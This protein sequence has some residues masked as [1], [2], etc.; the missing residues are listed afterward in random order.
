M[1]IEGHAERNHQSVLRRQ[2][3]NKSA[4]KNQNFLLRQSANKSAISNHKSEF[5]PC[6]I[7]RICR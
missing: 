5:L 6:L 2:S 7:S 1:L 3:A 4:I